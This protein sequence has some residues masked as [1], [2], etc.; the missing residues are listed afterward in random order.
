MCTDDGSYL[1][2]FAK[3]ARGAIK[4]ESRTEERG[5]LS[6]ELGVELV[7]SSL[8][9]ELDPED[10]VEHYQALSEKYLADAKEFLDKDVLVQVSE[11]LWGAVNKIYL[12][13]CLC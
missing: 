8:N 6:G 10:L 12:T 9:E 7:R 2:Y 4:G 1:Y 5:Y 3:E 13:K 11:K